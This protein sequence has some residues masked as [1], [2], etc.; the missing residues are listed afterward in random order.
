ME[1]YG[2][3][4]LNPWGNIFPSTVFYLTEFHFWL[5]F[6]LSTLFTTL[7][8]HP[9]FHTRNILIFISFLSVSLPKIRQPLSLSPAI[10][11]VLCFSI[12]FLL[13]F[14]LCDFFLEDMAC[15]ESLLIL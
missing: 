14:F 6:I 7:F 4:F 3:L 12:Y 1:N 11:I 5:L 9:F 15:S 10:S 2:H 13:F 8:M